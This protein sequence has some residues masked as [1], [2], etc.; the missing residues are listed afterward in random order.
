MLYNFDPDAEVEVNI[1]VI[2][3]S[4]PARMRKEHRVAGYFGAVLRT[5]SVSSKKL[6]SLTIFLLLK[7]RI[8]PCSLNYYSN[9]CCV[10][11]LASIGV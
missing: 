11:G 5:V 4:F 9:D 8:I 6:M 10:F 1:G 3:E 2:A 7:D